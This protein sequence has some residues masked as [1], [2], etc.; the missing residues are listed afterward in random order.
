MFKKLG[1]ALTS[2][3]RTKVRLDVGIKSIAGLPSSAGAARVV[4]ARDSK[5]QMTKLAPVSDGKFDIN[6][7]RNHFSAFLILPEE[8]RQTQHQLLNPVC[9]HH[10]TGKTSWNEEL[11]I[12]ATLDKNAKGHYEPKTYDFRI[13]CPDGEQRN[14]TL[15]K[16]VIDMSRYAD[17]RSQ[18]VALPI[19]LPGGNQAVLTII[20][21]ASA[22]KG[23]I[24]DDSASVISGVSGL[25][26]SP[27]GLDPSDQDLVGF[28]EEK[29]NSSE[30]ALSNL[31]TIPES[32][33]GAS[34]GPNK[35]TRSLEKT[36]I[37]LG[38]E[39]IEKPVAAAAIAPAAVPTTEPEESTEVE[40][41]ERVPPSRI[42]PPV[43][44]PV[45][46]TVE[47]EETSVLKQQQQQGEEE[48]EVEG[49]QYYDEEAGSGTG[50]YPYEGEEEL[51][52]GEEEGGEY[53]HGADIEELETRL[54]NAEAAAAE[55]EAMAEEAVQMLEAE[56]SERRQSEASVAQ[57]ERDL[58][59]A[60]KKAVKER[61]DWERKMKD[62][63]RK[64]EGTV[65]L[66]ERVQREKTE[67]G[68]RLAAVSAEK[69]DLEAML[70]RDAMEGKVLMAASAATAA[71]EAQA[72]IE[73]SSLRKKVRE[74]E[75]Y[76]E[77][78]DAKA[79]K[80]QGKATALAAQLVGAQGSTTADSYEEVRAAEERADALSLELQYAKVEC[81]SLEAEVKAA[82]E[83][84]D[85]IITAARREAEFHGARASELAKQLEIS[86]AAAAAAERNVS[87]SQGR[88]V[89]LEDALER[90]NL[91]AASAELQQR[92]VAGA[93]VAATAGG[94]AGSLSQKNGEVNSSPTPADVSS[95]ADLE[96]AMQQVREVQDAAEGRAAQLAATS[97]E[98]MV[99]QEALSAAQSELHSSRQD[100]AD[101]QRIVAARDDEVRQLRDQLRAKEAQSVELK[102]LQRDMAGLLGG[103]ASLRLSPRRIPNNNSA[104]GLPSDTTGNRPGSG[105]TSTSLTPENLEE[106][107]IAHQKLAEAEAL[108]RNAALQTADLIQQLATSQSERQEAATKITEMREEL[109][110]LRSG[111]DGDHVRKI[112][113]LE[114]ELLVSRNRAEVNNLFREEHERIASDLI[115]TKLA[116]AEGQEQILV[117]KRSLIKSQERSMGF[118]AKLTKLE[119][120]LYRRLTNVGRRLSGS[121]TDVISP[122]GA[123][124]GKGGDEADANSGGGG[125]GGGSRPASGNGSRPS[126][127]ASTRSSKRSSKEKREKGSS[128]GRKSKHKK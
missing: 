16:A 5:V 29:R 65:L 71:A 20:I 41:E 102:Q 112:E 54:G 78:A 58:E 30:N 47:V 83:E 100:L 125:S 57:L 14:V 76:V 6:H 74:M 116:W 79:L 119:T 40:V 3:S 25:S 101:A 110:R 63:F 34:V 32:M 51:L 17:A 60:N 93:A 106:L 70:D 77:E 108:S 35:E 22:V 88:I 81:H 28:G 121:V 55:A 73:I 84:A 75:E 1:R 96:V 33:G 85:R 45:A 43:V 27:S 117:L 67:L 23:L 2:K 4:W 42:D 24:G 31:S 39:E 19:T 12:I 8:R 9:S 53:Y 69:K 49:E 105:Q 111:A 48:E 86:M 114:R 82:K 128:S 10:S 13:Q 103:G 21:T 18:T 109:A 11:S 56:R 61:A 92:L 127:G 104:A 7:P 68:D 59:W 90:S 80:A 122:G 120:K 118:A 26:G 66:A 44:A 95:A 123:G 62:S 89:L 72:A 98:L 91:Q 126:S 94:A 38:G 46:A 52:E 87:Q 97:R 37:Q 115:T 113:T 15:G 107:D 124:Q 64:M 36:S 99:S 50:S